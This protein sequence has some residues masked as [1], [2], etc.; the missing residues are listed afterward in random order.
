MLWVVCNMLFVVMFNV[1]YS[2]KLVVGVCNFVVD[3]D[4]MVMVDFYIIGSDNF[5]VSG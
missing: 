3:N 5:D 4:M 2:G 1:Y